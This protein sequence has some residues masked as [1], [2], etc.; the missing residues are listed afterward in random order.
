VHLLF[1]I[2]SYSPYR[3]GPRVEN[4]RDTTL[5]IYMSLP[6]SI[7][8]MNRNPFAQHKITQN[9]QIYHSTPAH[10]HSERSTV[11]VLFLYCPHCVET[12][13]LF[14]ELATKQKPFD[15]YRMATGLGKLQKTRTLAKVKLQSCR[16]VSQMLQICR[17]TPSFCFVGLVW[18]WLKTGSLVKHAQAASQYANREGYLLRLHNTFWAQ[19]E[20]AIN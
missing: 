5:L 18:T 4:I 14:L 12:G 11:R 8:E 16:N 13:I 1:K 7:C 15:L 6:Y 3:K 20:A 19:H 17:K 10:L 9:A 2:C